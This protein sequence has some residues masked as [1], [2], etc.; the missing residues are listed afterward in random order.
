MARRRER[1]SQERDLARPLE[2][3]PFVCTS[4][5]PKKKMHNIENKCGMTKRKK[6]TWITGFYVCWDFFPRRGT[7]TMLGIIVEPYIHP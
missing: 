1:E 7:H 3:T 5:D 2:I 6:D 4:W